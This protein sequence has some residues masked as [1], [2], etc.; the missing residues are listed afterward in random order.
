[1]RFRG[2][3]F[4]HKPSFDIE[5]AKKQKKCAGPKVADFDLS[6]SE[7]LSF[8]NLKHLFEDGTKLKILSEIIPP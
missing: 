3:V 7:K 4:V 8:S 2:P 5:I 1:M 6:K